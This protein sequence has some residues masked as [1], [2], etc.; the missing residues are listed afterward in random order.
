MVQAAGRLDARIRSASDLRSA[1]AT[2]A[3]P[4]SSPLARACAA[5]WSIA[6]VGAAAG[7]V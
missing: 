6:G 7:R 2:S 4:F 3:A 1:A 5:R